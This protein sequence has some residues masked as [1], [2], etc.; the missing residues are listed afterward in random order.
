MK[1]TLILSHILAIINGKFKNIHIFTI[2][3]LIKEKIVFKKDPVYVFHLLQKF[4]RIS[5]T[6]F[7][8][9]DK[10]VFRN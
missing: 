9:L 8:I 10:H 6:L 2:F 5:I 1:E 7:Y 4:K 3:E